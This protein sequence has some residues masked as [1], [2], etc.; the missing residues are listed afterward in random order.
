MKPRLLFDEKQEDQ[1]T[2]LQKA[3]LSW[4]RYHALND[5]TIFDIFG[6]QLQSKVNI[7]FKYIDY[8]SYLSL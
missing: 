2:A 8:L 7:L 5:S 3:N 6:G 4:N 1:M